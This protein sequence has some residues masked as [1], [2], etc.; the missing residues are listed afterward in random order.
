M[1]SP[2]RASS[3]LLFCF[4]LASFAEAA[5]LFEQS[6][7]FVSRQDGYFAYRIPAIET[8]PDG[9]LLAFA[10]GRKY[11]LNDPGF[12]KQDIDLVM[13]R[14]TKNGRSWSA[15]KVIE[16][17]GERWSAA[18]P[19]TLV[20]RDARRIWLF[21]LRGKPE[22]NTYSARP[23]TDD[24]QIFA[25]ASNDNGETWSEPIDLTRVTRDMDDPKWRTSVV[26]PGG[27]IQT[28]DGRLVI[29]IWKYAPWSVFTV[30]S[31]DHGKTWRRGNLVP[32]VVGDECQL[33]ELADGQWL[34][35]IRQQRGAHRWRVT[36]LDGG[37]T[38]S[39]PRAGETV[40]PVACAM[41]RFTLKEKGDDRDRLVW[42]GPKGPE[43]SNLVARVSY[44][45][46]ATFTNE[47]PISAGPAAYSDL[48]ILRDKTVGVI[49]ERG[50]NEN[51]QFISFTRFDREWLEPK[52]RPSPSN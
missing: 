9:S 1:N 19:C 37:K 12:E 43:R 22:R 24:I 41:E 26:G 10:E 47:R 42:T 48:T 14:S 4:F 11:H 13:K 21:Y 39:N 16:D 23:G 2:Q 7:V 31:E 30:V 35:D 15:M 32:D 17:P 44:D 8:A 20:D 33:V 3:T 46:G 18:N 6:D 45:E 51:Y 5:P 52:P 50:T 28:R 29:P 27:G 38:W 34:F 36:S 40:S 25:R 49:W